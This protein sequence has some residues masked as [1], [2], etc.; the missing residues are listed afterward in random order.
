MNK[1]CNQGFTLIELMIVVA[2]IGIIAAVAVPSYTQYVTES[3]RADAYVAL[4]TAAA[5]QERFYTYDNA[6]SDDI[7]QLG[8]STSP[9]GFYTLSVQRLT[10]SSFTMLAVPASGSS[11][12][13][14]SNCQTLTLNHLG[15]KGSA[16]TVLNS[17]TEPLPTTD[18]NGCW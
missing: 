9:E 18:P 4:A 14:D 6:Y 7:T 8:G 3:R 12:Q 2:I 15:Q 17:S 11:Q 13:Q 5:E 10:D 16:S 1:D